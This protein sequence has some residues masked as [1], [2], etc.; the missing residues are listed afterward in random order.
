MKFKVTLSLLAG[1]GL[2]L[3]GCHKEPEVSVREGGNPLL[4]YAPAD[5]PYVFAELEPAPKEITDAYVA[6]AQ[7]LLDAINAK[8]ARFQAGYTAAETEHGSG[9]RLLSAVLDEL[10]GTVSPES[11]EKIGISLQAHHAIYGMGIFPV[12]RME[13]GNAEAL[14]T[15]VTHI[16]AKTG[17][18]LPRQ[19]L[20]GTQYWRLTE[21]EMPL[22][23]YIAILD[24]QLAVAAFPVSAQAAL[25]PAF[26]GQ[27]SPA[28]SI[29]SGKVLAKLNA[30]KGYTDYGSGFVDL[31]KVAH[32][33][34]DTDSAT[35]GY[36]GKDFSFDP[37]TLDSVCVG[38][39][40]GMIAKAP[41]ITAGTTLLTPNE[42]G[43][44]YELEMDGAL[45][46]ALSGIV[47]NTPAAGDGGQLLD[48]SLAVKIGK[49]RAFMLE[50]ANELVAAPFQC[51]RFDDFNQ[52]ARQM[53]Q[54]L[55]IP[56]PPMVNNLMGFRVRVDDIDPDAKIPVTSALAAVHVDKPEMFV[57]MASMMVPGLEELDLP[58]Q[59]EPV[60]LP[61]NMIPGENG[62]VFALMS[63]DAIGFALGE[64]NA[65][66]LKSFMQ[67]RSRNDGTFFSVSYDLARQ[68]KI[69]NGS[70]GAWDIYPDTDNPELAE[71]E[72]A[73][74]EASAAMAGTM[75]AEMKFNNSGIVI[76]QHVTFH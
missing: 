13:L 51:K 26:L 10:G 72:E 50:K 52:A 48:A 39:I 5:T 76:D 18:E 32:E 49:L 59:K 55:N 40:K 15:A 35:H 21:A 43:M 47:S 56:M 46:Q 7:P 64:G 38:E 4:A 65:A 36:L 75:R 29:A 66:Q 27:T 12:M 14:R 17:F 23:I 67:A 57:G 68:M 3:S 28:Q 24:D 62:P 16:E 19:E 2:L 33:I 22:A 20:G 37:A 31:Q 8:A 69:S 25:L 41:R 53:V 9:E 71:L 34:F 63:D 45:A 60:R 42:T 30:D 74:R 58:N 1:V 70:A 61:D 44:R 73:A 54:Q 11:L 6:R